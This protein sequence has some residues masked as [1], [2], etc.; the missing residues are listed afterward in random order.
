MVAT[1]K[2]ERGGKRG[3]RNGNK[4]YLILK[5]GRKTRKYKGRR[6][7]RRF[8]ERGQKGGGRGCGL[9]L[10][11][12]GWTATL[13]ALEGGERHMERAAVPGAPA[14]GC[15]SCLCP[16]RQGMTPSPSRHK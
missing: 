4:R 15:S 10:V 14:A 2:S 11:R 5:R 9:S 1:K 16:P 8:T 3:G 7:A 13:R 12:G 6:E